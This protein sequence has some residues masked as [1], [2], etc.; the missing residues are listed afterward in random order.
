MDSKNL[1]LG[2]KLDINFSIIFNHPGEVE[3]TRVQK[4]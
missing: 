2:G 4:K 3:E 1:F